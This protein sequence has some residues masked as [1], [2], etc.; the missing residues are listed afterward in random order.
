MS[1]YVSPILFASMP[2][3][4]FHTELEHQPSVLHSRLSVVHGP[5]LCLWCHS[6]LLAAG[7]APFKETVFD[8][9]CVQLCILVSFVVVW[10]LLKKQ[11]STLHACS[12]VF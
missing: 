5:W 9:S 12:S 1:L 4:A 6:E 10:R 3:T 7:M 11:F 2:G 8:A